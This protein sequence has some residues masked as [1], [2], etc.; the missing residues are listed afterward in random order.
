MRLLSLNVGRPRVVEWRGEAVLT[1]IFKEPVAGPRRVGRL[2][3][4]GDEQ[5]D[6]T[7]HGGAN[8]AVYAYPSEHFPAWRDELGEPA[9]PFG[10][11]GEN[12][13]VQ[14]LLESEVRVGDVYRIGTVELRVTQPRSPCYKLNIRFGRADM[15]RRFHLSGRSGFYF[16]VITEGVLEAGQ[17]IER[18]ARDE[19]SPT[20]EQVR[21]P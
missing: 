12:L 4:E 6:L 1:S 20:I 5:S 18:V 10:A 14:G 8:K 13:T 9:L 7:V 15:V 11:F 21:E 19:R 2:N 16:A 3:V 17:A